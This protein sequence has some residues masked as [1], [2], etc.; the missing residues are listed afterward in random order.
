MP[1]FFIHYFPLSAFTIIDSNQ[2]RTQGTPRRRSAVKIKKSN[3]LSIQ[4]L[5]Y[6]LKNPSISFVLLNY[7]ISSFNLGTDWKPLLNFHH[8]DLVMIDKQSDGLAV[9]FRFLNQI[10]LAVVSRLK[11]IAENS[12]YCSCKKKYRLR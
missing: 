8:I 3:C 2:E 11:K 6:L 12:G 5:C 7:I 4:M 9:D 1:G 10:V